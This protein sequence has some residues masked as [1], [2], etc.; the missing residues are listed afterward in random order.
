[1]NIH[2]LSVN[3]LQEQDR[4]LV[5]INT[6]EGAELRL[7]FTRRLSL[8][9]MPLLQKIVTE[10][11]A[12]QEAL[13]SITISPTA[14]A[15]ARTKAML[16]EFKKEE[17]LQKS[18]FQTPFKEKPA[19]LP[20][21]AK[22]LLVTEVNVTPLPNGQL[23]MAFSEKLPDTPS[24]RSFQIALEAN[25]IHGFVHLLEKALTASLWTQGLAVTAQAA[26]DRLPGESGGGGS[27]KPKYLN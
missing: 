8:G 12:K 27:E 14:S 10:Q 20:L 21:G 24:A 6:T 13:K 11:V 1:M 9:L 2:Q 15:D 16:A 22:P 7:W 4:I 25:L 19:Q 5:R 17:S 26:I 18:D 3:Y 23:Q